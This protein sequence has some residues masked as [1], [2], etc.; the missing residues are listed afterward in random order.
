MYGGELKDVY[1]GAMGIGSS[2][3]QVLTM[4]FMGLAQGAQPIIGFNYGAGKLSRVK[5]AFKLL[6]ISSVTLSVLGWAAVQLFPGAFIA[7]FND[8][9]DLVT[10][11]TWALHVYMGC[12]FMLGIQFS[13]QNTFVALGQ[14]KIS[15]FLALL[16]KIILLIPL[17]YLLPLIITGNQVFAVYLAEPVADFL[18]AAATGLMFLYKFPRILKRREAELSQQG[19]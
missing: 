11:A 13:C 2:I 19:Q 14:A 18:A 10:A 9:Q 5:H 15:L 16:R 1:V 3:M 4:P 17:A 8:E 7:I 6:F 12:M